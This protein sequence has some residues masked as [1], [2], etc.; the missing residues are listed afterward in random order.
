MAFDDISS[1]GTIATMYGGSGNTILTYDFNEGPGGTFVVSGGTNGVNNKIAY[2]GPGQPPS[3]QFMGVTTFFA[4][5]IGAT[6]NYAWYDAGNFIRGINYGVDPGAVASSGGTSV[7]GTYVQVNGP[8]TAEATNSLTT[9]NVNGNNNFTLASGAMLTVLGILK[10]GNNAAVI[11]GGLGIRPQPTYQMDIYTGSP[12]DTL[13]IATPILAN[14]GGAV[15][16][17]GPGTVILAAANTYTAGTTVIN[18]TLQLANANAVPAGLVEIDSPANLTFSPGI[19]AVS[20]GTLQ[21]TGNFALTD[22][23]GNP[24]SLIVGTNIPETAYSGVIGGK[25]SLTVNGSYTMRLGGV[26]TYSGRTTLDKAVIQVTS[27]ANINTPSGI[28]C[29]SAAGSASDLVFGGG[30]LLYYS[31]IPAVTNR[32]FTIGDSS[33]NSATIASE[34]VSAADTLAFTSTS[35]IALSQCRPSHPAIKRRKH[36]IEPV[37]SANLATGRPPIRQ[38]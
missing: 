20:F 6:P 3:N 11:N 31:N 4:S 24:V 15:L 7:A 36:R 27:L 30:T 29:G 34:S 5:G 35:P 38:I 13:T 12:S 37:C 16:I 2:A 14:S 26:N 8:V 28:G 22:I 19:D 25:G 1:S 23:G 21:G 32:L 33:G 18:G 10:T 17:G 9:L